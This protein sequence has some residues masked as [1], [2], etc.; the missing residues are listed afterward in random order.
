[1][2]SFPK[3]N[4]RIE[5]F[6]LF[7]PFEKTSH[8]SSNPA[9]RAVDTPPPLSLCL[10]F[11]RNPHAERRRFKYVPVS[12]FSCL[13]PQMC[14]LPNPIPRDLA[15]GF[16]PLLVRGFEIPILSDPPVSWGLGLLAALA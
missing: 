2:L 3:P 16:A 13:L 9:R 7:P 14:L 6:F 4:V 12:Q 8:F 5:Q 15:P 10:P 11:S 1:M